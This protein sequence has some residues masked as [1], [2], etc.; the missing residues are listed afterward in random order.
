M[1]LRPLKLNRKGIFAEFTEMVV[2][3]ILYLIVIIL[4]IIFVG[5][6]ELKADGVIE[7]ENA[8]FTCKH[9]IATFMKFETSGGE[10][11][12]ELVINQYA[13]ADFLKFEDE[14][15]KLFNKL[16]GINN[17]Q[18]EIQN[19]TQKLAHAGDVASPDVESCKAF[20]P[21]PCR[22]TQGGCKLQL[23][24]KVGY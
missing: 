6:A 15:T 18:L 16:I 14:V 21:V 10:T 3:A 20:L 7:A 11:F 23:N 9:N 5:L 4:S 2:V 1:K 8:R 24:L 19:S 22:V 17:W 13:S 12:D